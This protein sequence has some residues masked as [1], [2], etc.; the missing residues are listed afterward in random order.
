MKNNRYGVELAYGPITATMHNENIQAK[1]ENR[2]VL[3]INA[4][5]VPKTENNEVFGLCGNSG[6]SIHQP[7]KEA[8][9]DS[10][11]VE[12]ESLTY[13]ELQDVLHAIDIT[14]FDHDTLQEVEVTPHEALSMLIQAIS[15]FYVSNTL[16]KMTS[17]A[18]FQGANM[19]FYRE[20]RG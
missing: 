17:T 6:V 4:Y 16:H 20:L 15:V 11:K 8:L 12:M 14:S 5:P 1:L 18:A 3:A 2:C 9:H 10:T 19:F 13:N 7:L